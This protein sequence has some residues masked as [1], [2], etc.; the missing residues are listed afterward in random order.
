M[1]DRHCKRHCNPNSDADAVAIPNAVADQFTDIDRHA[2][3]LR[4]ADVYRH[5]DVDNVRHAD[6]FCL[7]VGSPLELL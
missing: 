2:V 1:C 5:L 7:H 3:I 4:D 6:A